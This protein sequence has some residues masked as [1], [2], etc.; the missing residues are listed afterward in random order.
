MVTQI[1]SPKCE[2]HSPET[3]PQGAGEFMVSQPF[4]PCTRVTPHD[5]SQARLS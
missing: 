2:G 1:L 3:H 5:V 4:L